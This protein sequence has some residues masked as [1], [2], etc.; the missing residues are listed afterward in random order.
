MR[1]SDPVQ[2]S[3]YIAGRNVVKGYN[4][5]ESDSYTL[6]STD[7]SKFKVTPR[8]SNPKNWRLEYSP[9]NVGVGVLKKQ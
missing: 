9:G 6:K 3:G 1:D 2:S 5:G 4:A 8:G 7:V